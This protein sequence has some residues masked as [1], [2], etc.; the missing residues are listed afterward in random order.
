MKHIYLLAITLCFPLLIKAQKRDF[1]IVYTSDIDR[2]WLAYD[3]VA[4]TSDTAKQMDFIQRLYVDKATPGLNAFMKA[5]NYNAK[6]WTTLINKYPK[7]WKSIR[8]NTLSIKNQVPAITSS[9]ENFRKLYPEMR[10]AKMYFTIGGLRS[11]GTTTDDMVL[12]GAEI[13]TADKNTDASE[14]NDWLKNVFKNQQPSNLVALN[15]H[16]YV[17][18]QQKGGDGQLLL[19]QVITEGAAD[20]IAELVT[21]KKNNNA[22]MIYGRGHEQ[23][24]KEKFLIEMFSGATGNW[25]YNGSNNPH[26]DLGYFVG[27]NICQA[28]YGHHANKKQAIKEII[29]LDYTNEQ[30]VTDFL[31]QSGYYTGP[32]DKQELLKKFEKMQPRVAGLTPEINGQEDVSP[33]LTEL[34]INFSEPMGEGYSID[35]GEGGKEHFPISGVAGFTE[36]RKSFKLKLALQSGKTYDF[37]ITDKSFKSKAGYP[38]LPYTVHF[39]VK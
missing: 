20:F 34:S 11:G 19:A 10:P 3:S 8:S 12:V 21:R 35:F 17:H 23:E 37:V 27:Y 30:Q 13:A 2:F 26:A 4:T 28:Y 25:L 18:T 9:I 32:I 5:R 38:L 33:T 39:K 36:D 15:V 7:F 29:E 14:L 31:T 22:Y 6:L 16:E 24:L 1:K